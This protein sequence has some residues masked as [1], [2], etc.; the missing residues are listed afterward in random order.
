MKKSE[1]RKMIRQEILSEAKVV[2]PTTLKIG[3]KYNVHGGT[4]KITDIVLGQVHRGNPTINIYYDYDIDDMGKRERGKESNALN[5]FMNL[6]DW[7]CNNMKKSE[8]KQ[9]IRE[10]YKKMENK[11]YRLKEGN[12]SFK[13]YFPKSS[14]TILNLL[15]KHNMEL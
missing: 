15:K 12:G 6:F 2:I 9:M 3:E 4:V 14:K 7:G 13:R 1:L 5:A 10:E 11:S 8:L